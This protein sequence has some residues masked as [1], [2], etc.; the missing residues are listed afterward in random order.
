MSNDQ[1]A[2]TPQN[3]ENQGGFPQP[4][5]YHTPQAYPS[6]PSSQPQGTPAYPPQGYPQ[7][8][9]P[10]QP[11]AQPGY[12]QSPQPQGQADNPYQITHYAAQYGGQNYP[13]AGQA[14][15]Y[16]AQPYPP[17]AAYPP[18]AKVAKSPML[19]L[20]AFGVLLL[21]IVV[22]SLAGFQVMQAAV[23]LMVA[24]GITPDNQAELTQLLQQ[25][26]VSNYPLQTVVLNITGW[27][28]FAAWIAGI[29]ATAMNRGR[30]W[31]V[32]TIILGVLSPVIILAV[33][34]AAMG[35]LLSTLR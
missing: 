17:Q 34:F 21:C 31:G 10:Q 3:P 7:Q 19:G 4:G 25:E 1:P 20:I 24:N 9:Y 16:P 29:V 23:N 28:G 5:S 26:L 33:I 6:Q 30:M 12:G 32:F 22:G 8:G 11:Y 14:Q 2:G 35:P 15:Q 27:G 18:A 13:Q